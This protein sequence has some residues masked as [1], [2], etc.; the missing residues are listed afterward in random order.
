VRG[1]VRA[2][3]MASPAFHELPAADRKKLAGDVVKVASY[4]AELMED[5]WRQ[6]DRLGQ[7]PVIREREVVSAPL[8]QALAARDEFAPV[9]ANQ[10]AR[11]TGETLKAV[12]FPTFVADLINGTFDAIVTSNIRQMESYGKL[13]ENVGRTVDEFMSSN[14][15]DNQARDWL[16]ETYPEHIKR[17]RSGENVVLEPADGADEREA[18]NWRRDLNLNE[19]ISLD[20]SS[21]EEQLVPAARRR[22]AEMRLQLLSTMVLM[23]INR[24]VVTGGKIRATMGF[25]IDSSDRARSSNASDFDLRHSHSGSFGYGPWSVSASTSISYVSSQRADS[26]AELNVQTDLTGEVEIHFKGDYF[27]I[28]R[29]ATAGQIGTI[30]GNTAV[31]DANTPVMQ[32]TEAIPWGSSV[33]MPAVS[34]QPSLG[35]AGQLPGVTPAPRAVVPPTP[36]TQTPAPALTPPAQPTQTQRPASTPPAPTGTP[37]PAPSPPAAQQ[38]PRPAAA[39]A[40]VPAA[41]PASAPV[42]APAPSVQPPAPASSAPAGAPNAARPPAGGPAGTTPAPAPTPAP[43]AP[44]GQPSG[45]GTAAT[46]GGGSSNSIQ[47]AAERAAGRA[48][49]TVGDAVGTGVANVVGQVTA[50]A[51]GALTNLV[52]GAISGTGATPGAQTQAMDESVGDD[53]STGVAL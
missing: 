5:V 51:G 8:V 9:A 30:R 25:H 3:L 35:A 34:R 22:L 20:E 15:T 42:A 10:V 31:P 27:P 11:V 53:E 49:G 13:L 18:P 50:G 6:S 4:A 41:A 37:A 33:T 26:D 14:I 52:T 39:P 2:L 19:D 48:I 7:K 17:A 28:E 16:A 21:L 45:G 29:F 43:S 32:R 44:A 36:V 1:Q 24:I 23:G 38:T 40:A 12:A 46:G 47:G